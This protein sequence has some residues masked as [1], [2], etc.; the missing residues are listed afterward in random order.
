MLAADLSEAARVEWV[1]LES[2]ARMIEMADIWD[3]ESRVALSLVLT[4]GRG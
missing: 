4:K 2:V 1:P 3:A